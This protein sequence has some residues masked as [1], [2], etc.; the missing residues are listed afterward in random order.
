M[1]WKKNKFSY[2]L[3]LV[4][5]VLAGSGLLNI[6]ITFSYSLECSE[7]LGVPIVG[8]AL[9]IAGGMALTLKKGLT[10]IDVTSWT[11]GKRGTVAECAVV[12][13]LVAAGI[14]LRVRYAYN[15]A[16]IGESVAFY[17]AA[18]VGTGKSL[19][20][21]V[22]GASY[23]YLCLLQAVLFLFGNKLSVAIV[24]QSVLQILAGMV[25]YMA[26]RKMAGKLAS[27]I[28]IGFYM[29]SPIMVE[30]ALVLSPNML[31]LLMFSIALF[32]IGKMLENGRIHPVWCLLIGGISGCVCYLDIFGVVLLAFVVGIFYVER[33][34]PESFWKKRSFSFLCFVIGVLASFLAIIG[35]DALCSN[36]EYMGILNA[37]FTI[38]YPAFY[39]MSGDFLNEKYFLNLLILFI[40]LMMGVFTFLIDREHE[41]QSV[42]TLATALTTLAYVYQM[43]TQNQD[44]YVYIYIFSF[45]LAG[46]GIQN[47][48]FVTKMPVV[49][50]DTETEDTETEVFTG[51][52]A[53]KKEVPVGQPTLEFIDNPL[54]LPKKHKPRIMD[55]DYEVADDDDYDIQ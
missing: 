36:K 25:F 44:A 26:V 21:V 46:I 23:F 14:I 38:Y 13:L 19:P 42:W 4:Y 41:K 45:A 49:A 10:D 12:V 33:E 30:E 34:A 9:L 31:V 7:L 29:L 37:W 16:H 28:M 2:V 40:V 47:L 11:R 32:C 22:H 27:V 5:A 18:V 17:E 48:L 52:E 43:M 6:A 54:P 35:V 39:N 1:S 53:A 8:V 51:Q 55:Y 3:W 24:T 20:Q 15:I 50:E